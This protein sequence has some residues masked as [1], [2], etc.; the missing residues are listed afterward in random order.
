MSMYDD[1]QVYFRGLIE[2][3]QAVSAGT[4]RTGMTLP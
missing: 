2:F 1:Q 4:F 3:L